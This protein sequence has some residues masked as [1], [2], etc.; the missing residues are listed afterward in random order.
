MPLSPAE[1]LELIWLLEQKDLEKV[2]PK[3]EKW[4]EP[5]P[6]KAACGGRGAG[7]KSTSVASLLVQKMED[8]EIHKWFNG[9]LI[10]NTLEESSFSLIWNTVQKLRYEGWRQVP[11]ASKIINEKSGGYFRFGGFKDVSTTKGKKSL[12]GY[13]GCWLEECEDFTQDILDIILPTFRKENAEIW[14]TFNRNKDSDVPYKMFFVNPPPG[15]MSMELQPG[16]IDNPWFP[17]ILQRQLE[18]DYATR[19]DVAEHI[20][21]GKPK[22]QGEYSVMSRTLIRQAAKRNIEPVGQ[23]E[24]GVDVARFG[25]DDSEMYLREGLKIIKHKSVHGLKTTQIARIVWDFIDKNPTIPIKVDDTGV[26]GGVSD[27]LD[28]LGAKVIPIDNQSNPSDKNKYDTAADE[29][30]F[31]FPLEEADI[32]DD[33]ELI[34][35]LADRRWDITN[36]SQRKIEPKSAYKTRN[37]RSPDKADALLLCFYNKKNDFDLTAKARNALRNRSR[38]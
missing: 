4:R 5:A 30:W 9:R 38:R 21:G 10:Q 35:Q 19:P 26:G 22:A 3:F 12:D 16:K 7:A 28:D 17:E 18:H 15:T 32:P 14:L 31:E 24:C 11:S 33:E 37:G 2:A 36:K 25:D 13:D 29:M 34:D 20:W 8:E 27:A 6:Y 1:E 23:K